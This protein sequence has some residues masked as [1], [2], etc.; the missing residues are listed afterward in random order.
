MASEILGKPL[1]KN[2]YIHHKDGNKLNNKKENLLIFNSNKDHTI[3]HT[4]KEQCILEEIE[5]NVWIVKNKEKLQ[6]RTVDLYCKRCGKKLKTNLGKTGYCVDC[7]S[8]YIQRKV[9]R[10]PRETLKEEIRQYSFVELGRKYNVS[11]KAIRKWC[12][13][14]ELPKTKK[15]I[16]VYTNEEWKNI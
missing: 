1:Q 7:Y 13:K 12:V 5:P 4:Y 10:P 8:N 15:E 2:Y 6:D 16:N 11:D 3:F 14:Y 9:E